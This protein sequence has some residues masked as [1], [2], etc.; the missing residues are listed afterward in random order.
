M[1]GL[2]GVYHMRRIR[3]L[4]PLSLCLMVI[5][6]G[7]ASTSSAATSTPTAAPTPTLAPTPVVQTRT[8]TFKTED[9]VSL[10]GTLYGSGRTAVIFS[11]QTD[12]L[13][14]PW[15]G[16]AQQLAARGYLAFTYD[17]RGKGDSGGEFDFAPL[18]KDEHAAI[19]YARMHGATRVVLVG[20]SL[21]GLV[22]VKSATRESTAG[23]VSISAPDSWPGLEVADNA[24]RAIKAPK[25][26]VNSEHDT[27]A[28]D[29]RHMYELASPPKDI[30]IYA[31][32]GHGVQLLDADLLQRLIGF[33]QTNAPSRA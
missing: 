7:S 32:N 27:Y 20:A 10:S 30:H 19:A 17:Y 2:Q 26:F 3:A 28:E 25:L 22:V 23:I 14:P 5:G 9:G 4:V 12:T 15:I 11:N 6:C 24:V 21:G 33:V 29:T 13:Q 8:V 16:V 31:G 18:V 1:N